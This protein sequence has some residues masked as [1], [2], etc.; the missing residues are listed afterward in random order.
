MANPIKNNVVLIVQFI[1]SGSLG[2]ILENASL[3]LHL[4]VL[5]A[6]PKLLRGTTRLLSS[7]SV[8][9]AIGVR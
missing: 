7:A 9:Q 5:S 3:N 8:R 6:H 2:S 4:P 1:N